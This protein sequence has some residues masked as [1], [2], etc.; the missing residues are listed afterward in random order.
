MNRS[1]M[2]KKLIIT[3]KRKKKK[4]TDANCKS[5]MV[6]MLSSMILFDRLNGINIPEKKEVAGYDENTPWFMIY[7]D[8]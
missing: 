5:T 8:R 3:K 4:I 1:K 2:I 7:I 6:E